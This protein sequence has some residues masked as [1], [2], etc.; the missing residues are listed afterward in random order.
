[1]Q[2]FLYL[3][4]VTGIPGK[5]DIAK[6]WAMPTQAICQASVTGAKIVTLP[7]AV[8]LTINERVTSVGVQADAP[9]TSILVCVQEA[10][11]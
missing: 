3:L 6:K 4:I 8:T 2:W 11:K 10:V 5:A 1:M 7:S 9:A